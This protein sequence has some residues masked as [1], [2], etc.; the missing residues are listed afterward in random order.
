MRIP[1]LPLASIAFALHALSP[2]HALAAPPSMR[3][4][5]SG[6]SS[7]SRARRTARPV[8]YPLRS[9]LFPVES[10]AKTG[11]ALLGWTPPSV[12]LKRDL[13]NGRARPEVYRIERSRGR[14][15]DIQLMQVK[16][17]SADGRASYARRF[18]R[19]VYRLTT[20]HGPVRVKLFTR[21]LGEG[22][23]EYL[24]VVILGAR[25]GSESHGYQLVRRGGK[26]TD[27]NLEVTLDRDGL[28][29]S[30]SLREYPSE[31]LPPRSTSRRGLKRVLGDL[32]AGIGD[33]M[34][35]R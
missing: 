2:T 4:T 18:G 22:G 19:G 8:R 32:A 9:R 30:F 15:G 5:S 35:R 3:P 10:P 17:L 16:Y 6:T 23:L 31:L 26:W 33:A 28:I 13:P 25:P 34:D 29:S 20:N 14:R 24:G 12:I 27:G 7:R 11:S 1:C 21:T